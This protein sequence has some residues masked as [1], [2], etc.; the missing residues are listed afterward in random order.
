MPWACAVRERPA[1]PPDTIP[2]VAPPIEA[3]VPLSTPS[4]G[5]HAPADAT[6]AGFGPG[7]REPGPWISFY[8]TARQMGDIEHVAR[9]FRIINIDADPAADGGN[10]TDAQLRRLRGDGRNT[11]LSYLNIGSCER[12]RTYWASAPNGLVPCGSN[13]AAWLGA[14][15]GYPDETW[16]DPSNEAY[17]RLLLD[18]VARRIAARGVDGFYLDNLEIAEHDD[19]ASESWCSPSCRQGALD[20]VRM[21]RERFPNLVLVMQ[22]ATGE[23]MRLG[24]TGGIPFPALLDGVVHESVYTPALD[25]QAEHELMLWQQM[26]LRSRENLPFFIGVEDYVGACSNTA[27]ARASYARSRAHG[28]A[29]YASDVSSSQKVTC[30][31]PF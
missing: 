15:D 24:R 18:L 7:L 26:G 25:E 1:H 22:N 17:R 21:I 8:G 16:M 23:A 11:V 4:A 10:F 12:V 31:W 2:A 5:D 3:D 14:Y 20:L 9:A 30:Y 28:F 27:A 29:P 19:P 6:I 13:R